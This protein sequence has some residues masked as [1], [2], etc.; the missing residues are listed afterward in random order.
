MVPHAGP[1]EVGFYKDLSNCWTPA[2][3]A[4]SLRFSE[5]CPATM[6]GK[7]PLL[8]SHRHLT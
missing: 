5:E 7:L 3:H 4:L 8:V 2:F 6:A 1:H